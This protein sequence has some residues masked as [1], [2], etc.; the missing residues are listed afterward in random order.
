MNNTIPV[1][2]TVDIFNSTPSGKIFL[3]GEAVV[4]SRIKGDRYKVRFTGENQPVKRFV[5]LPRSN[6]SRWLKRFAPK[7]A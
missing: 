6:H 2:A 7:A 5:D 4:L 3:E 1:N